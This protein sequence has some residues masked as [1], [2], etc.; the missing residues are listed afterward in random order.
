MTMLTCWRRR[1]ASRN[2]VSR[3]KARHGLGWLVAPAVALYAVCGCATWKQAQYFEVI[4]DPDPVTGIA[5]K[6][7]FRM[8]ITGSGG[9]GVDYKMRAAYVSAAT[10]DT[11]NGKIPVVPEADLSEENETA[12]DAIKGHYLGSLTEYAQAK[13][14]AGVQNYQDQEER[15]LEIARQSWFSSLI[16]SDLM[17]L[18][19]TQ[20]LDPYRFR[21]LVFYSSATNINLQDYDSQINSVLTKVATLARSFKQRKEAHQVASKNRKNAV[22]KLFSKYVGDDDLAD[23]WVDLLLPD[24]QK[25]AEGDDE[26]TGDGPED[27]PD[28]GPDAGAAGSRQPSSSGES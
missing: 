21:K 8:T 1:N 9:G 19:Q 10:L 27:I 25:K 26:E 16:D 13:R 20:S 23:D 22:K 15:I 24:A 28:V 6:N 14:D 11:L 17:S 5:P 4:G 2:G 7:Y 3:G 18:G 12:Y